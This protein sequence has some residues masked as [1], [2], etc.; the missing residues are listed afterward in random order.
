M[1]LHVLP[2]I[3]YT[4]MTGKRSRGAEGAWRGVTFCPCGR[5][6]R[7]EHLWR[8][9][10]AFRRLALRTA[11]PSPMR[12]LICLGVVAI[13]SACA[14][15][16]PTESIDHRVSADRSAGD[17]SGVTVS[18]TRPNQSLRGATLDVRISG[19][20]FDQGSTVQFGIDG[21]PSDDVVTNSVTVLSSTQ[22]IA[23]VT[24]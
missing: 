15:R 23:N 7:L 5:A 18:D 24:I 21:V 11:I 10:P 20:G 4:V 1:L 12:W 3:M 22:L 17:T 8:P 6:L 19:T 9:F 13:V 2:T 16:G 14:E